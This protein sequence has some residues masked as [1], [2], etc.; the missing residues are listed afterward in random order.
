MNILISSF[1]EG[2][3]IVVAVKKYNID[4]VY[5]IHTYPTTAV[6][7]QSKPLIKKI[8][9]KTEIEFIE[10][11]PYDL[12]KIVSSVNSIIEKEAKNEI[13]FN[14][15]ESRKTVSFGIMLGASINSDK[16]KK[17]VYVQEE[18][19]EIISLPLFS[20]KASEMKLNI[21][22]AIQKNELDNFKKEADSLNSLYVQLKDLRDNNYLDEDNRLTDLGQI[23]LM[24]K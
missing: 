4:R 3:T 2:K 12:V 13:Y 19:N 1:Y 11:L 7:E 23:V 21:L 5:L 6:L 18:T 22:G 8:L 9:D 17:L 15:T 24:K 10:V 16:A 14:V 20:I